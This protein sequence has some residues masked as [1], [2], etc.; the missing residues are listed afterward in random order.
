MLQINDF[1]LDA[2]CQKNSIHITKYSMNFLKYFGKYFMC[3]YTMKYCNL[4]SL[5]S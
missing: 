1:S 2:Q 3:D 4:T 5:C